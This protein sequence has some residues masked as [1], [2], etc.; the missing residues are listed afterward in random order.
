[1]EK[2]TLFYTEWPDG[3]AEKM[4]EDIILYAPGRIGIQSLEKDA[5]MVDVLQLF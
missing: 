1:M 5:A 4:S 2:G 3:C